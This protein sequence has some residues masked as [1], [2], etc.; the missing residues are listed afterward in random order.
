MPNFRWLNKQGVES[1]SGFV[2]Q[3]AGRFTE[4][5]RERDRSIVIDVEGGVSGGKHVLNYSRASFAAW[6]IDAAEQQRAIDNYREALVFMGHV[7][8]EY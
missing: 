8:D 2:V 4:E 1:E 7:P 3:R 5:Y 6:S